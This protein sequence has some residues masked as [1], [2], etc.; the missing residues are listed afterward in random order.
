MRA[1]LYELFSALLIPERL[2]IYAEWERSLWTLSPEAKEEEF[3]FSKLEVYLRE[4]ERKKDFT[5]MSLLQAEYILTLGQ[6]IGNTVGRIFGVVHTLIVTYR[7]SHGPQP[8]KINSSWVS[9][10]AY[11]ALEQPVISTELVFRRAEI[12]ENWQN[13]KRRESKNQGF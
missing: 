12:W 13:E 5:L 8:R 2:L 4:R 1:N 3:Q 10:T 6:D 7:W 11:Q 9:G